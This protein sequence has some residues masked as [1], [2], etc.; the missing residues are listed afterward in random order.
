MP[1]VD[2]IRY[3]TACDE[4]RDALAAAAP[5][6][7]ARQEILREHPRHMA[8]KTDIAGNPV[9]ARCLEV[10][11]ERRRASFHPPPPK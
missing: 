8:T 6:A 4:A 3:C 2:F 11:S 1:A 9:C 7:E 5:S 10:L